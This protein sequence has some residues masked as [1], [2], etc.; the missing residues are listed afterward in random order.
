MNFTKFDPD[1]IMLYAFPGHLFKNGKGTKE[2]KH[3][4]ANDKKFIAEWYPRN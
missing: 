1:S 4:S 2:N 3:L